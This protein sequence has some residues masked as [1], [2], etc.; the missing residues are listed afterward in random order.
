M[1]FLNRIYISDCSARGGIQF[2]CKTL[3]HWAINEKSANDWF[4]NF[5]ECQTGKKT[6]K[7]HGQTG[8]QHWRK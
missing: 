7:T 4:K 8:G 1:S 2:Y 3:Y 5:K 6:I